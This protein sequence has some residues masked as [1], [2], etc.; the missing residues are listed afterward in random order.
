[1]FDMTEQLTLIGKLL[2][3]F[4]IGIVQILSSSNELVF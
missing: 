1:M 4:T 3:T 2:F